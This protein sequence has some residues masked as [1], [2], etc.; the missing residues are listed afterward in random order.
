MLLKKNQS[1]A[2]RHCLLAS[3]RETKLELLRT[4]KK[5]DALKQR[6]VHL[7]LHIIDGRGGAQTF[8]PV[9]DH[10]GALEARRFAHRERAQTS[11]RKEEGPHRLPGPTG[12][13]IAPVFLR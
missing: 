1:N 11:R 13:E 8:R 2:Q 6:K 4:Y 12:K 9:L 10:R 5:L 7:N 3:V